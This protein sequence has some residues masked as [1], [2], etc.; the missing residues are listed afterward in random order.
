MARRDALVEAVLR[1]VAEHGVEAVTHRRV[2]ELAGLPLASTTYWFESKDDMLAA[3]LEMAAERD[4]E[5]LRVRVQEVAAAGMVSG[6]AVASIFDPLDAD[7]RSSRGL[8]V[9][10]YALWL[11]AARRPALQEI[12]QRWTRVYTDTAASLLE[13][14]G[15]PSP[16]RDAQVLIAALDG[17]VMQELASGGL[18]HIGPSL[19]RL[20]AALIELQ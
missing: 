12:A 15:S 1:V 18:R 11:E 7:L 13:R 20:V 4:I 19:N 3:A 14:C 5:R 10:A 9:A 16:S 8:L 2:A 6:A 17:M